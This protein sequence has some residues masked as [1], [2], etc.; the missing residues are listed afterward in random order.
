MSSSRVDGGSGD[1]LRL[2]QQFT[3]KAATSEDVE[4]TESRHITDF[5]RLFMQVMCQSVHYLTAGSPFIVL[6]VPG[7]RFRRG[8]GIATLQRLI[9]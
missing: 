3:N 6:N 8:D 9:L 4:R 5:L 7:R 1:N 2:P